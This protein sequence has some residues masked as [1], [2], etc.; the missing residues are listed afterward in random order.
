[1]DG[2]IVIRWGS[3]I[4]GREAKGLEVLSQAQQSFDELAKEHRIREHRE[5]F[6]I[7]GGNGGFMIVEGDLDE[8]A[9]L[10]HEPE[11]LALQAKAAAIVSDFSREL[12]GGGTDPGVQTIVG[13]YMNALSEIGYL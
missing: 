11:Q 8:L 12:V 7:S 4:P 6:S 13:N 5:Y 1:M 3:A 10:M 2:A 9:K